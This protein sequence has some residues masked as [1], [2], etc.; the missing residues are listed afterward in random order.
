MLGMVETHT[1]FHWC[2]KFFM[3]VKKKTWLK[4]WRALSLRHHIYSQNKIKFR[5]LALYPHKVSNCETERNIVRIMIW[6]HYSVQT[7]TGLSTLLHYL[8]KKKKNVLWQFMIYILKFNLGLFMYNYTCNILLDSFKNYFTQN[9]N[10][11]NY[12]THIPSFHRPYNFKYNLARKTIRRQGPLFWNQL[13]HEFRNA[14][15]VN[16]FK[17][18][19]KLYLL[20]FYQ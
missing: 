20:S 3:W 6:N 14:K 1:L 5:Y 13:N 18:K 11:H 7:H 16:V 12:P 8:K 19:Y 4:A 15:S 9:R 2:G 17:K 10:I